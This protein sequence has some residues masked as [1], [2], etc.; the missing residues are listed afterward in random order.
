MEAIESNDDNPLVPVALVAFFILFAITIG[1]A[2]L[3]FK[4]M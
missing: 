3:K 2:F 1:V 4:P